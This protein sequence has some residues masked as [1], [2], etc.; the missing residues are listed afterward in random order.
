MKDVILKEIVLQAQANGI[1]C[2]VAEWPVKDKNEALG[3]LKYKKQNHKQTKWRVI[4]R[5]IKER[6]I[7]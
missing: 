1:W 4:E 7:A 2:R 5:T 6:K 3:L